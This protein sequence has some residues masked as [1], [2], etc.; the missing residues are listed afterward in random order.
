MSTE[1]KIV[2]LV[3]THQNLVKFPQLSLIQF[4]S[5]PHSGTADL[6]LFVC[7]VQSRAISAVLGHTLFFPLSQERWVQFY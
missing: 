4:M 3:C 2:L 7:L 6:S 1:M 5:Y